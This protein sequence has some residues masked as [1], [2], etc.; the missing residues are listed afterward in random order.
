MLPALGIVD[1]GFWQFSYVADHYVYQSLPALLVLAVD[2][3]WLCVPVGRPAGVGSGAARRVGLWL[4]VAVACL[5]A[6]I[7]WQ[8]ARVYQTEAGLWLDT[9][10]KK[11]LAGPGC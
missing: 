9:L 4:A 5:L 11:Q 3:V 10:A 7:S 8:R 1:V 6:V 2:L